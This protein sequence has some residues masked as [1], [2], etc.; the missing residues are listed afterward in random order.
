MEP[1]KIHPWAQ[2]G[3]RVFLR[4]GRG[5]QCLLE[6]S[7]QSRRSLQLGSG[8]PTRDGPGDEKGG[9][10]HSCF[11]PSHR[12]PPFP[13]T[14]AKTLRLN[15]GTYLVGPWGS[16]LRR[17][18]QAQPFGM[19]AGAGDPNYGVSVIKQPG[20]TA[21][22]VGGGGRTLRWGLWREP[23]TSVVGLLSGPSQT[24]CLPLHH[25]PEG[26]TSEAQAPGIEGLEEPWGHL[27]R[28]SRP[29]PRQP[30]RTHPACLGTAH[31]WEHAP[32]LAQA[33]LSPM[34]PSHPSVFLSCTVQGMSLPSW[35]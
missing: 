9:E 22:Q 4:V 5:L 30:P 19:G 16:R 13:P 25:L 8:R 26:S 12:L 21:A 33:G 23:W 2:S 20:D 10:G 3:W 7:G 6:T 17:A 15:L 35:L 18:E 24:C 1:R 27:G 28:P 14:M 32:S 31:T 29:G 11:L 34:R